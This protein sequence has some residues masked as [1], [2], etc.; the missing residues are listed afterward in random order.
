MLHW[1]F[2]KCYCNWWYNAS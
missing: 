2:G 1:K